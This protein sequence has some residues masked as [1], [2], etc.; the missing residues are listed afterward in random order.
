MERPSFTPPSA[1]QTQM[2]WLAITTLAMAVF[3][4]LL[5]L[6]FWGAGWVLG[7]LTPVVLPLAV[8]GILAYLLDPVVGYFERKGLRRNWAIFAV[9]LLATLILLGSLGTII[10]QLIHEVQELAGKVLDQDSV[11][12]VVANVSD[13]PK[14][15]AGANQGTA[16]QIVTNVSDLPKPAAGA[17]PGYAQQIVTKVDTW[18]AQSP[19]GTRVKQA[20]NEEVRQT[21][22]TWVTKTV[23]TISQWF[24]AQFSRVASW[25]GFIAGAALIPVYL[26]YFLLE[27]RGI[28]KNWTDY[29]PIAESRTKEEIVF[30]LGSINDYLI[31]FFR[32]QV[33]VA[34][35]DG[36][37]LTMGFLALG[38]NY[39]LLLGMV[40]GMLSIIPFLGVI[41]SLVPAIILAIVQFGDWLHP[42]LVLG[43]FGLVQALEGFVIAPKIMGDRVGLHPMTIMIAVM[44]GTTLMGG[45]VGGILAIPLT[46]ALRV[47]MFRYVWYA[48]QADA[49][50]LPQD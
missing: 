42:L 26:F 7:Q 2:I 3:L 20:W 36:I 38:M 29:L 50:K 15:T 25:F 28:N 48:R 45:I 39:A 47:V 17:S 19:L 16:S 11:K 18:L 9:F 14:P 46:A 8:A 40:A 31:L 4:V 23:P 30:V 6:L 27:K 21:V 5:G 43:L 1:R 33:L 10:P 32:G 24:L 44:V 49:P 41:L 37:L 13:L 35:C 22:L 34:L 12:K